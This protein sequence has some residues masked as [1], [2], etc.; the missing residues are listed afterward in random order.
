MGTIKKQAGASPAKVEQSYNENLDASPVEILDKEE[1]A[2]RYPEGTTLTLPCFT[3]F[4]NIGAP[5]YV[6]NKETR[7]P[8]RDEHGKP[9]MLDKFKF[10]VYDNAR[11]VIGSFKYIK[12]E[13][14]WAL[15]RVQVRH[16][17]PEETGI[18][19]LWFELLNKFDTIADTITYAQHRPKL[20]ECV[21]EL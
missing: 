16:F 18:T 7:K 21:E 12:P 9:I 14:S 1:L 8:E 19:H 11:N 20:L 6:Y 3:G 5:E 15:I 2:L 17:T 13:I 10:K 4:A